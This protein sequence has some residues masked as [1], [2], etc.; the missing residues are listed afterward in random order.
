MFDVCEYCFHGSKAGDALWYNG[1]WV[2][3]KKEEEEI[4]EIRLRLSIL[5]R[6]LVFSGKGRDKRTS[7][8]K[9]NGEDSID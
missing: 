7:S 3:T 2:E 8:R 9:N 6:L 4:S 5:V 1:Q